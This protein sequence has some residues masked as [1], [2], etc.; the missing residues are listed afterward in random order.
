MRIDQLRRTDVRIS[1]KSRKAGDRHFQFFRIRR[2]RNE[3][4]FLARAR[5]GRFSGE[6]NFYD[7]A[8]RRIGLQ[9]QSKQFQKVLESR[10]GTGRR[11]IFLVGFGPRCRDVTMP[12]DLLASVSTCDFRLLPRNPAN[13]IASKK[14]KQQANALP[15]ARTTGRA[16]GTSKNANGSSSV[17]GIVERHFFREAVSGSASTS[18]RQLVPHASACKRTPSCPRRSDNCKTGNARQGSA[19][20]DA[21]AM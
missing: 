3:Q 17:I 21:P 13:R 10:I 20:A 11:N 2:I 15:N 5:P 19:G 8:M 4:S 12:R 14:R 6:N 18:E 9:L 7:G 16:I 1:H